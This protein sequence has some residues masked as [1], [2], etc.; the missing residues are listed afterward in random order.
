MAIFKRFEVWLLLLLSIA[1]VA[2]VLWSESRPDDDP[3]KADSN[4]EVVEEEEEMPKRFEIREVRA[5]P[6]GENRVIEI[7]LLA[8]SDSSKP[9]ELTPEKARLLAR[10]EG[11]ADEIEL[12]TF[13][14]PFDPPP[15]I[16]P[17]S[18]SIVL[19]KYWLEPREGTPN[20]ALRLVVLDEALEVP[21]PTEPN[22]SG[23]TF[24]F[25]GI[26]YQF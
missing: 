19:L 22:E 16:E 9:E 21:F 23:G 1:G 11:E 8:R 17:K 15:L 10:Y 14:L 12:P 25:G 7:E 6:E 2:Y 4:L 20:P 18:E 13:F 5:V 3:A 24:S 26:Q